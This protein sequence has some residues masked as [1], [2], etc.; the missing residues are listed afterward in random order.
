MSA[1]AER[2]RAERA[3]RKNPLPAT[4]VLSNCAI[5][6]KRK[7]LDLEHR[8]CKRCH[9]DAATVAQLVRLEALRLAQA[10]AGEV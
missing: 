6:G 3:A 4:A 5:C 10:E 2:R 8:C 1:R 7:V 9:R